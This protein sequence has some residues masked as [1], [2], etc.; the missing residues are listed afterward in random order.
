MSNFQFAIFFIRFT[1]EIKTN[2]FPPFLE[3]P[4]YLLIQ[5]RTKMFCFRS[6]GIGNLELPIGTPLF[7]VHTYPDSVILSDNRILVENILREKN[8]LLNNAY[9]VSQML[10]Q[11]S[12]PTRPR[13]DAVSQLVLR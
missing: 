10:K 4:S 11:I 8:L 13:P 12:P 2:F 1:D 6:T 9:A 5:F 7:S 3:N